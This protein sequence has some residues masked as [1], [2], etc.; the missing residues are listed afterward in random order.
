MEPTARAERSDGRRTRTAILRVAADLASIEGLSGLSIGRLASEL[1]M[2]KSGV[3]AHFGS[4]EELQLATV[5]QAAGIYA[6]EVIRPALREPP[7]LARL[8][9]LVDAF[10]S[11]S[12]RHVF[13]GGCFFGTTL[14]E[15]GSRPGR[16]RDRLARGHHE[17]VGII[18]RFLADARREGDV[19]PSTDVEQLA[20]EI[21]SLLTS[22]DWLYNL[23]D[24]PGELER[25]RRAVL[26]RVEAAL[27]EGGRAS[28]LVGRERDGA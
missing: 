21:A 12:R 28:W 9:R 22:A 8:G 2:S 23:H 27:T 26:G 6:D 7:G 20:F 1:G 24:D 14:V 13:P 16:L 10:V 15:F 11:Y 4:M 17:W 3:F 18:A 19:E 25:G 5:E